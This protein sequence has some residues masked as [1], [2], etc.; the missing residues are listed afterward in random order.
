[1]R[2]NNPNNRRVARYNKSVGILSI[3]L[4]LLYGTSNS[5]LKYYYPSSLVSFTSTTTTSLSSSS[6]STTNQTN[7]RE[8]EQGQ[9]HFVFIKAADYHNQDNYVYDNL[10]RLYASHDV[11]APSSSLLHHHHQNNNN[12]NNNVTTT[13]RAVCKLHS[14]SRELKHFPHF[15]QPFYQCIDFWIQQQQQQY[16]NI[17][18]NNIIDNQLPPA[19]IIMVY[20]SGLAHDLFLGLNHSTFIQGVVQVLQHYFDLQILSYHDYHASNNNNSNNSNNNNSNS[21]DVLWNTHLPRR[22][23]IFEHASQWA[24]MVAEYYYPLGGISNTTTTTATSLSSLPSPSC[25]NHHHRH[26]PA[27]PR[28]GILNRAGSRRL[29]QVNALVDRLGQDLRY[30]NHHH[31]T[32][33]QQQQQQQP[34]PPRLM[35]FENASFAEQVQFFAETDILVSPHGAQLTGIPFMRIGNNTTTASSSSS[36]SSCRQVLEIFPPAYILPDFFGT[37]TVQSGLHHSYLYWDTVISST[38][39]DSSNNNNSTT[40]PPP[41]TAPP[42]P[43]VLPGTVRVHRTI[44]ERIHD[45]QA[46]IPIVIE[47]VVEA[48]QEL[49]DDF[50][51]CCYHHHCQRQ[52]QQQQ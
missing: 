23:Y 37:L 16:H 44:H 7:I 33:P 26:H 2:R 32:S 47:D 43:L 49:V 25:D 28:I 42:P 13:P 48:V 34:P 4:F 29:E 50:H 10:T 31:P 27:P 11:A 40:S 8:E 1:M 52:Q 45:R 35:Y 15:M 17:I 18:M 20:D 36:C 12:N 51:Q 9:Q 38:V 39:T 46:P 22:G 30:H 21:N 24:N 3:L 19:A 14:Q 41:T 6:S 5:S